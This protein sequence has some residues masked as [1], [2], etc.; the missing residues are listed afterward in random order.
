MDRRSFVATGLATGAAV[1]VSPAA[2]HAASTLPA[3]PVSGRAPSPASA[4][5]APPQ[6]SFDLEEATLAQLAEGMRSGRWTARRLAEQYLARIDALDQRGP[7]LHAMLE[8]NPDALAIADRLD[9]ERRERG[10]RGPL[11]GVPV[12]IKDNIDTADRMHTSAG[13]LALADSIAPRDS[14]VAERLRAAGAVILGKTNCSEWA[15]FRGRRSISGWSARGGQCRNPY[16]L[17]RSPSGSSSGSAVT[18]AANLCAVAIGTETD[19]SI[20]SPGSACGIVGI[21]PTVGLVSRAGI[22]PIAHS[23]DTAG[24]MARCVADAAALLTA[25]TGED[26]RDP[27]TRGSAAFNLDYTRFLDADGLRGL[28]L[29]I[30]RQRYAG[31]HRAV[32][33][34]FETALGVLHERGAVIVDPVDLTTEDH[35][36]GAEGTV[37]SFEF[38]ADLD[39]YLASLG[40]D[41]PVKTMADVI[42]FN[43]RTAERELA[44]FGQEHFVRAQA[45]GPLTSPEYL[46]ALARCRRYSRTLG[47]DLVM[48]RHRVDAIVCPTATP[49]RHIDQV[50]GDGGGGTDCTT[51]AAVAGYPHVTVPMGYVMGVPVGLSFF[52]RAWSEAVL[53]KAAY[54][55]EQASR[56]RRPPRFLA[57]VEA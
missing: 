32:D 36:E 42:A 30:A 17:D 4:P 25:L 10:P 51:P 27:A 14:S 8:P 6:G 49:P 16:V 34:L 2:A 18:V 47:I 46:R 13:S 31:S 7:N 5:A 15:N 48:T 56:A 24:P 22:I 35:L 12:L 28:R 55:Y 33:A 23:Q 50:N 45:R 29:G 54:A 39:A 43:E 53:I 21:K 26:P 37:L 44:L 57:T 38:K 9:A 20:I 40:P 41:A 52:G 11:H 19:G 3:R 1:V